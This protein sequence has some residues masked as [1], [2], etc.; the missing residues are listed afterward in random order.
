ME[1][2]SPDEKLA[3]FPKSRE[4]RKEKSERKQSIGNRQQNWGPEA[5]LESQRTNTRELA[6]TLATRNKQGSL[7]S[8]WPMGFITAYWSHVFIGMADGWMGIGIGDRHGLPT[9]LSPRCLI[10]FYLLR[11]YLFV[12]SEALVAEHSTAQHSISTQASRIRL[13]S[14]RCDAMRWCEQLRLW[15]R[16]SS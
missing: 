4:K 15:L 10:I 8:C 1:R 9:Y 11:T 2:T 13:P 6:G 12:I 3:S 5:K 14:M 7:W 16:R